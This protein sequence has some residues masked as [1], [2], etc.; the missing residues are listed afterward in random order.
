MHCLTDT[1]DLE[2]VNLGLVFIDQ[3]IDTGSASGRLFRNILAA[4][5][6][7][8]RESIAERMLAGVIGTNLA[9]VSM[10]KSEATV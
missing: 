10:A 1:E 2:K 3:D 6:E 8:E 9:G 4:F 5:A 7:F